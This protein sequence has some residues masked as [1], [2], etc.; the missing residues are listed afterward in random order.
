VNGSILRI[1]ASKRNNM[2]RQAG[3]PQ[4]CLPSED[5]VPVCPIGDDS[6]R[7]RPYVVARPDPVPSRFWRV[8]QVVP[9]LPSGRMP[10]LTL[11]GCPNTRSLRAAWALEEVSVQYDYHRV[12][13]F[14]GEHRTPGFLAINPGGKVPAL[15]DGSIVVTES[16]AIL[17]HIGERFAHGELVPVDA[18]WRAQYFQWCFFVV[19]ELEQPLWTIAK[20]R[21]ALPPDWRVPQIE[22]TAVREFGR[23]ARVAEARLAGRQFAVGESFT[24]ADILIA[25]TL[26]WAR[27]AGVSNPSPALETYAEQ[28]WARPARSAADERERAG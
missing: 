13:L 26:M 12:D 27:S 10:L 1:D 2:V 3:G 23:A 4:T 20:H 17:T 5:G 8:D 18:A 28:L 19:S 21:F 16:G 24:A 9:I 15:I 6:M 14:K 11:Y 25:H 22:A 7:D